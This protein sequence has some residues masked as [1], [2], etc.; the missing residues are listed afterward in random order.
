M[1]AAA[2]TPLEPDSRAVVGDLVARAR[3]AMARFA[4][5][6]QGLVDDAVRALAWALY[7]P[8][9]ARELAELAVADTGL[10]NV[11]DKVRKTSARPSA[12][13]ATSCGSGRSA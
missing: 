8:E 10:G 1:T 3:A 9:H 4:G 12:R 5:A 13:C 6:D 2:A 7:R 11:D